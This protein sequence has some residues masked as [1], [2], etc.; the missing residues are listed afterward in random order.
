MSRRSKCLS[1]W[2]E[3]NTQWESSGLPQH[4]FCEQQGVTYKQ[5]VYW[6]MQ[7]IKNGKPQSPKPKLLKV[8]TPASPEFLIPPIEP[9]SMLE[10]LMPTGVKIYIKTD[11][12][13]NKAS[14]LIKRLGVAS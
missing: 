11:A 9:P 1:Y 12:D 4:K 10:V 13:V 14:A 5:F 8:S 7:I 2:S 6:R 3:L